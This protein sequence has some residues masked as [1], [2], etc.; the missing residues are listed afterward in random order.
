MKKTKAIIKAFF[1]SPKK[2]IRDI[3]PDLEQ[4]KSDM[5]RI[6]K[7]SNKVEAVVELFKVISPFHDKGGF[8][9]TLFKLTERNYGQLDTAITAL[10]SLQKHFKNAGR[11]E[12]GMN[13]TRPDEEVTAAKV[14]LGE[15]FGI[16]ANPA[17]YWLE[18]Q[19]KF[20]KM[21]SGVSPKQE[22]NLE[23]IS[24]WYCIHD[25]KAGSFLNSHVNGILEKIGI[26]K[27]CFA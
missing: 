9:Q 10:E 24:V 27:T 11:D 5:Q 23:Y 19:E 6:Q 12:Y 16:W 20:E 4:L 1:S 15:V 18:N 13:R 2:H 22:S 21:D 8:E 17:S 25:Y 7:M 3:T 26:L 14:Y